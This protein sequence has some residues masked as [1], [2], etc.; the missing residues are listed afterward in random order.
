MLSSEQDFDKNFLDSKLVLKVYL[1]PSR[2]N[3]KNLFLPLPSVPV[4]L[5]IRYLRILMRSAHFFVN[6]NF[7]SELFIHIY[8]QTDS[9]NYAGRFKKFYFCNILHFLSMGLNRKKN[10]YLLGLSQIQKRSLMNIMLLLTEQLIH[11]CLFKSLRSYR[12]IPMLEPG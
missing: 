8:S 2:K 5:K 3:Q 6:P 10:K 11:Q 12:M 7:F 4:W 1:K 9:Q